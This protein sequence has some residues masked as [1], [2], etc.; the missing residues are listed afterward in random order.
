MPGSH[1][2]VALHLEPHTLPVMESSDGPLA[3]SFAYQEELTRIR[4]TLR[5]VEDHYRRTEGENAALW[6]RA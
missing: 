3:A 4:D 6:G 1:P 5:A 2:P